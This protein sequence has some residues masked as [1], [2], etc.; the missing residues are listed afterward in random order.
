MGIGRWNGGKVD[1]ANRLTVED[2]RDFINAAVVSGETAL[3]A[4]QVEALL[5]QPGGPMPIDIVWAGQVAARQSNP[6]VRHST[7]PTWAPRISAQ[8]LTMFSPPPRWFSRSTS[9]D[10]QPDAERVAAN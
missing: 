4:K 3:A 10:S 5:A 8:N 1:D 6:A 2:R 7:R 9:P